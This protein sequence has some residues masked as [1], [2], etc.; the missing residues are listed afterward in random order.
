MARKAVAATLASV[1]LFTALVVADSTITG[2]QDNLASSAQLSHIES[3]E[4]TMSEALAGSSSVHVLAQIQS[5]LASTPA[6]CDGLQQYLGSLSAASSISGEDGGISY[7]SDATAIEAPAAFF[8]AAAAAIPSMAA[9][10]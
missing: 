10:F 3:R 7:V 2:A 9:P 6:E 4:L 5:Y 1:L 8:Q